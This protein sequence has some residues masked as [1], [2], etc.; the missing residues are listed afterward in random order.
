M[1]IFWV[2]DSPNHTTGYG[3]TTRHLTDRMVKDGHEVFVFAPGA[4]HHGLYELPNGVTQLTSEFGDDRWGNG[5]IN[6]LIAEFRPDL[7]ITWLDAQGL[8]SY[9]WTDVP[10]Y[11][12][13]PIDT[14]PTPTHELG[15][16][17]RARKVMSPSEWGV[18]ILADTDMEADYIPCGIDL[19]NYLISPEGRTRWRNQ[20]RPEI[21]EDTF[22]VGMVGLNTG[23]PDRK[24]YGFAFDV[25]DQFAKKHDD[26]RFYLHTNAE[27]GG[28]AINLIDLRAEMHLEDVICFSKPTMSVPQKPL[29]MRDMYNAF[30]AMLHCGMCEGFGMPLVEAQA[31]GTPIVFNSCTS[32]TEL[33]Q[34]GYPAEPLCDM[35]VSTCT[36]IALPSVPNMLEQLERAYVDWKA[37]R[38]LSEEKRNALHR[39]KIRSTVLRFDQD[40]IYDTRWRPLLAEAPKPFKFED[41]GPR[42]LMLAAGLLK[43]EGFTHHDREILATH[44]DIAHD[45]NVFPYPWEDDSWD[46][47]EFSDCLEHL[48]ADY[49]KVMD[50]LWRI[51]A[52]GGH[53]YIHTAEAGSWQLQLDPTHV[54]G[55]RL[56]SMDYLDPD[57]RHGTVYTY[58]DKK[59][60]VEVKTRDPGGLLFILQPRKTADVLV[61]A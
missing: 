48:R 17:S 60:K 56:E 30:D 25:M 23:S 57:T 55:F 46:Y 36:R 8:E 47:I 3:V 13:A 39:E 5:T 58:S 49:I 29:F 42:K 35:I 6:H 2:S 38:K 27:G 41:A 15:I 18:K 19:D 61:P 7:I 44:H 53:V 45:L 22:L 33:V 1:R 12:W 26:V 51:T 34:V 32:M 54:Q 28:G 40:T 50:E 37:Q 9:A 31:C 24:G 16:L 11:M 14:W 4:A 10:V 20:M 21:T 43:K 59:W 52:P